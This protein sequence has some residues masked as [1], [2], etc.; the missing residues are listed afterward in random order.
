[1]PAS[2]LHLILRDLEREEQE[3]E[4]AID[5][6]IREHDFTFARLNQQALIRVRRELEGLRQLNDPAS[7]ALHS[8]DI[9]CNY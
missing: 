2:D 3:L 6:C 4:E 1:M 9:I 5:D 8:P 7:V